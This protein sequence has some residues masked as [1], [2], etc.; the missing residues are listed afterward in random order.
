MIDYKQEIIDMVEKMENEDF[1]F[2][3]FHYIIVKYR[4]EVSR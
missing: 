1:L 3:I 4:K 2:K